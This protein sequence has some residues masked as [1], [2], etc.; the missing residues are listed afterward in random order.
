MRDLHVVNASIAAIERAA[1]RYGIERALVL[2]TYFPF[3]GKGLHN[4]KLLFHLEGHPRFAAIGSLDAMNALEPGLQELET[5]A[6]A[7]KLIGIKLYPGYQNIDLGG[8]G[9]ARVLDL[10]HRHELPVTI[11]GGELHHCCSPRRRATNDLRCGNKTCWIDELGHL[12]HPHAIRAAVEAFPGVTFLIAH[13]ANPF[14]EDL[15]ELMRECPNVVTDISGQF[16][17]GTQED[18]PEYREEIVAEIMRFITQVPEGS[19]RVLFASDFPIQAFADTIALVEAL[20]VC[21]QTKAEIYRH[22]ALRV[23]PR[24]IRDT[25]R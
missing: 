8:T 20:P 25:T 15:R 23:Y 2:A 9:I 18:T 17:S 19:Q 14:F 22:N 4:R 21:D 10:A 5:L 24:L 11:H 12:A 13:L 1:D 16:V 6:S 3:K 7:E